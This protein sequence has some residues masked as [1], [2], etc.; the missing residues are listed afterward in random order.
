MAMEKETS[1]FDLALRKASDR[2]PMSREEI[3]CLLGAEGERSQQLF[4]AARQARQDCFGDRIFAYGFVYFST[5]C[6]NNCTFCF[7]RRENDKGLRYRK[8]LEEILEISRDLEASGIHMLDL[9]MGEDPDYVNTPEGHAALMAIAAAMK[10]ETALPLMLSP[11]VLP[12]EAIQNA[13]DTGADWY[14]CYQET[15]NKQL[16]SE[17]RGGQDYDRRFQ[18]KMDAK[19]AGMLIEEGLLVGVGETL[20]DIADSI[21]QMKEM[22]AA[23]VRVMSYVP[24]DGAPLPLQR[25]RGQYTLELNTIAVMRLV[26]PNRFIP[27]S[28]DVAGLAGLK[29]RLDAGANIVT[30]IIAPKSGLAGVSNATLDVSNGHRSVPGILPTI[31]E[32]G[33]RMGTRAEFDIAMEDLH[34][35]CGSVRNRCCARV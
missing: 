27:A 24:Q 21:L 16:Y 23:Q 1:T 3:A 11:G 35:A 28:L 13:A 22:G 32:C 4:A 2:M 26:M 12:T 6:R 34:T 5:Y 25:K 20:D 17:L 29:E 18:A 10:T 31:S 7:Y 19:K 33:L 15:H 8:S 9:T 30:S 14:A